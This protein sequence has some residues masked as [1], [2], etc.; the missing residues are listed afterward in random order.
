MLNKLLFGAILPLALTAQETRDV[1]P[2][3]NWSNPLYF[4]LNQTEREIRKPLPELQFSATQV[5]SDATEF[6]G[7]NALPPIGHTRHY[8]WVQQW[9]SL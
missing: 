2:L 7:D 5:S 4:Q 6:R 8:N 1:V 3:K 9:I